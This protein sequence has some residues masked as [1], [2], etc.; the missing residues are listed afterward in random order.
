MMQAF[1]RLPKSKPPPKATTGVDVSN[2][3]RRWQE[4]ADAQERR[5]TKLQREL[6]QFPDFAGALAEPPKKEG[7]HAGD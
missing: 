6:E 3:E 2:L 1:W 4:E 5:L 7:R